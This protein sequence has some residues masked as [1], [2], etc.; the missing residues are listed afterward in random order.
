MSEHATQ[1]KV[2]GEA[3]E[4]LLVEDNPADARLTREALEEHRV[5]NTIHTAQDGE[6]A[7]G[8]LRREG[9]HEHAPRPDL[10]FLDL[11]LPKL[12]GHELLA[13]IKEDPGLREIPV[14]ILTTS[15]TREDIRKSYELQASSFVTKPVDFET[16]MRAVRDVGLYWFK[17]VSLPPAQRPRDEPGQRDG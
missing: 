10:I 16:F 2:D 11:N 9:E 1:P 7:L 5:V 13:M 8:F 12:S 15:D 14:V 17:I 6:E 4:I 3:I